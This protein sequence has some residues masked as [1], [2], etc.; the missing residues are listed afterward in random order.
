[1]TYDSTMVLSPLDP[2]DCAG[3]QVLQV[4]RGIQ[5]GFERAEDCA[6]FEAA[7]F[8]FKTILSCH[9]P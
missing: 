3:A 5:A 4:G 8:Q 7:W 9:R 6:W 2:K 1:M